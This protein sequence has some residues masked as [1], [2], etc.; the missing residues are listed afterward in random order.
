TGG[1][2]IETLRAYVQSQ[3]TPD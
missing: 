1:A 3:S 2:T